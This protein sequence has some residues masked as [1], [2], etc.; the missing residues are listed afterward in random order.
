MNYGYIFGYVIEK[1]IDYEWFLYG[2][3]IVIGMRMV[4]DL[5]FFLGMFILKEY[6][7]IEDLLKK[8]DL[9]FNY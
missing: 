1:E 9:I 5:V 3:V 7:C 2:E 4:N 6:E 8:F